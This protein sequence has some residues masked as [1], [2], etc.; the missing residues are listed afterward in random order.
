MKKIIIAGIVMAGIGLVGWQI[1]QVVSKSATNNNHKR[2][3][4]KVAVEVKPVE[5][6]VIRDVREFTGTLYP[7]SQYVVAPKIAGRLK[8]LMFNIGDK[9]ESGQL[10]AVLEDEEFVQEVDQAR[11]ELQVAKANLE[12]SR[13]S[14][15]NAKRE[16]DRTVV[17][18]SKK[19][20]SESELDTAA[21]NYR[22]QEAKVK[23]ALAQVVQKEAA[24]KGAQ[25][26]LS[27]TQ[28]KVPPQEDMNTAWS[29]SV[30]CTRARCWRQTLRLSP[31]STYIL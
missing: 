25:V 6:A 20:A 23:V 27:Y 10:I 18:R 30:S 29:E 3:S 12:E 9:L 31:F 1:Y 2:Q 7:R 22:T 26:R 14:L 17:L 15:Q 5:K 24:L 13:S 21:S 16:Y 19:I 28:I 4:V 11:A 8:K